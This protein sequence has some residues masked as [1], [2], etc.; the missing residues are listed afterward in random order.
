MYGRNVSAR[1]IARELAVIVLPQ[2]S[3]KTNFDEL[4]LDL[5][6]AKTV[7]L[8]CDYAKQNLSEADSLLEQASQELVHAEVDHTDNVD[9]VEELQPVKLTSDQ[10]KK[11]VVA[12]QRAV[13]LIA[14][15]LDMPAIALQKGATEFTFKCSEC[16]H[17]NEVLYTQ[18]TESDIRQFLKQLLRAYWE[19][20]T[21]IDEFIR[22]AKSK[23]QVQR[24]VSIDRD[25]LRLACAEAFF[26]PDIPIS[27]CINE[28]VELCHRFAD[29]KAAK[30]INGILGDLSGE[31]RYFR[32]KGTMPEREEKDD[33]GTNGSELAIE[34]S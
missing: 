18:H 1:R 13:K 6:I 19:H 2:I 26:M 24:M 22:H 29:E 10:L 27:V 32:A 28:A 9:S 11:Q 12:L 23:W 5:L 15:A 8:L 7:N 34:Q 25:I 14:E 4:D 33:H 21:E 3:K 30:F 16:G 31:A 20:R 17:F